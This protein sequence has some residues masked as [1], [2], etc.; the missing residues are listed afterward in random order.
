MYKMKY[1]VKSQAFVVL[2]KHIYSR[3]NIYRFNGSARVVYKLR[4]KTY[5][6][7]GYSK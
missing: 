6:L 2:I 4:V 3:V 7:C 5:N 1:T